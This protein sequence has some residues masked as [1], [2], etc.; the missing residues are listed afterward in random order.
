MKPEDILFAAFE[1]TTNW[2]AM[3]VLVNATY[4]AKG[5]TCPNPISDIPYFFEPKDRA[6]ELK[7]GKFVELPLVQN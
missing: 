7:L 4:H 3:T 6:Y 1:Q 2:F 5:E